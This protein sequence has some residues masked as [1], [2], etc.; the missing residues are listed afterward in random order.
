MDFQ[1]FREGGSKKRN[2]KFVITEINP[3]MLNYLGSIPT[4]IGLNN[5]LLCLFISSTIKGNV[6]TGRNRFYEIPAGKLYVQ[7]PE[8]ECRKG[9]HA[10]G[11]LV[12]V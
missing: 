4:H 5:G 1:K 12:W 9:N 3:T 7:L 2:V 8:Y 10:Y 6:K 11:K